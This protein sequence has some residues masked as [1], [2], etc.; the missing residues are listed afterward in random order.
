MAGRT[1]SV[2][3]TL[4]TDERFVAQSGRAFL[5]GDYRTPHSA[6]HV[7]QLA[8]TDSSNHNLYSRTEQKSQTVRLDS[9]TE[10]DHSQGAKSAPLFREFRSGTLGGPICDEVQGNK[11]RKS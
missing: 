6:R 8:G 1:A 10:G 2:S 9:P 4:H 7:P 5:C 3:S 11:A